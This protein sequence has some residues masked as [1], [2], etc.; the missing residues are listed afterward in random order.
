MA[1]DQKP[2]AP[3]ALDPRASRWLSPAALRVAGALSDLERVADNE[4]QELIRQLQQHLA[5]PE[6]VVR[7]AQSRQGRVQRALDVLQLEFRDPQIFQLTFPWAP[8]A[9]LPSV[10]PKGTSPAGAA[11]P[12]IPVD[13]LSSPC[14]HCG[15][16][17]RASH[18]VERLPKGGVV[19]VLRRVFDCDCAM[20]G[21]SGPA[22]T[23][24]NGS[25]TTTGERAVG[26]SHLH[27]VQSKEDA[28]KD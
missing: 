11:Q 17:G 22:L 10:A 4:G 20:K 2:S 12:T 15:A 18:I 3:E 7:L 8:R 13:E 24:I 14:N 19:Q 21:Q 27:A 6:E 9:E 1:N 23:C 28:D 5:V 16:P 26:P 25:R